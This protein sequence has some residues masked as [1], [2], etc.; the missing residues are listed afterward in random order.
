M[1]RVRVEFARMSE[2]E[3]AFRTS[4]GAL[5]DE[6]ADLDQQLQAH[7]SDW[8]GDAQKAYQVAYDEW[9]ATAN[10]MAD[11]LSVLH[12]VIVRAH[13]NFRSAHS[14]NLTMWKR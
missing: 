7:L 9:H 12:Q 1:N 3:Q 8:T 4:L 2:A 11:A 10:D 13:R 14:A 6:L 5:L